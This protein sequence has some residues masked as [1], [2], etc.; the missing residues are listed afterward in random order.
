MDFLRP[1]PGFIAHH[2][3]HTSLLSLV[4]GIESETY[5][6]IVSVSRVAPPLVINGECQI[7]ACWVCVLTAGRH[8]KR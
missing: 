4:V 3:K 8:P 1:F 7:P 5:W 2:V 6:G